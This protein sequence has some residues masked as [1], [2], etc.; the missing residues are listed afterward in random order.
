MIMGYISFFIALFLVLSRLVNRRMIIN[1]YTPLQA[2]SI[3]IF[4]LPLSFFLLKQRTNVCYDKI[5]FAM[6][7]R[8]ASCEIQGL[9]LVFGNHSIV[10]CLVARV[11]SVF[12]LVVYK[13]NIPRVYLTFLVLGFSSLFAGLSSSHIR[14][15]GG[16]MCGPAHPAMR[17]LIQIPVLSYSCL[18]LLLQFATSWYVTKTMAQVRLSILSSRVPD[19]LQHEYQ[20]LNSWQT[21]LKVWASCHWKAVRLLWRTYVTSMFLGSVIVFA[22]IQYL[23]STTQYGGNNRLVTQGWIACVINTSKEPDF[24]GDLSKCTNYLKGAGI[25][26]RTL[27]GMIL[28]LGFAIIFLFTELRIYLFRSWYR[29]LKAGPKALLSRKVS[30][31]IL[32]TIADDELSKVW[33]PE[34]LQN[35]FFGGVWH[36]EVEDEETTHLDHQ[37]LMYKERK[38]HQESH[39]EMRSLSGT[40]STD[41]GSASSNSDNGCPFKTPTPVVASVQKPSRALLNK[42]PSIYHQRVVSTRYPRSSTG[43]QS[44][45]IKSFLSSTEKRQQRQ[46]CHH[47]KKRHQHRQDSNSSST[48]SR[49]YISSLTAAMSNFSRCSSSCSPDSTNYNQTQLPLNNIEEVEEDEQFDFLTFLNNHR[50]PPRR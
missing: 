18:G 20:H 25:Y 15:N 28:M 22:A 19:D 46:K 6:G 9:L 26:V 50:P 24:D 38:Q 40:S 1:G 12:L 41:T 49:S 45:W 11:V 17:R 33:M 7:S 29:L 2:I 3:I 42:K 8:N 37:I 43:I 23:I 5:T 39:H 44:N 31:D 16:A 27:V 13:K 10:L 4:S 47:K 32:D 14:F 35:R 48:S 21:Q 30:N 36:R 34:R